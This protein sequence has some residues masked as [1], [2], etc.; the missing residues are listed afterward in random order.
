MGL[1]KERFVCRH[2]STTE[3]QTPSQA[4]LGDIIPGVDID[5][6]HASWGTLMAMLENLHGLLNLSQMPHHVFIK[7]TL[8]LF[9]L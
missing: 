3:T 8:H 1:A 2:A 4:Q 7:D 5:T 9:R 6:H